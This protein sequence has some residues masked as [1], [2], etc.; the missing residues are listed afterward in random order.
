MKVA[1]TGASGFVGRHVLPALLERGVEI[2]A[3]TRDVKRLAGLNESI[4]VVEMNIAD[5]SH[6]CF[7][8]LG[9]PDIL[10]HLAWAGLPNYAS[11]HHF[12]TEL[13]LQFKFLKTMVE[14]GLPSLFVTGTCFE[15]GMQSGSLSEDLMTLPANPYGYAKDALR[16]QLEFLRTIKPFDLTWARLFY[17]YGEGQQRNSLYTQLGD[18]VSRKEPEFKMSGGNQVR[19]YLPVSE[20]AQLI[21]AL[22]LKEENDCGTVNICSGK[23]IIIRKL[24]EGWLEQ[25]GWDIKLGL[26]Q[27]PY[28]DYEPMAFWG[29]RRRLDKLLNDLSESER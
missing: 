3:V 14:A 25:S 11:L 9:K 27:F 8:R 18:A 28:P 13:P 20:A 10:I 26:G 2:V 17:I 29:D 1:V 16:Q 23:P 4:C 12:E 19:D 15:Y 6:D 24:V 22:A 7:D 5:S 21:V